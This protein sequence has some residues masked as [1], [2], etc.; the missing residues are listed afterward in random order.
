MAEYYTHTHIFEC[1]SHVAH[2]LKTFTRVCGLTVFLAGQ[3][4][5]ASWT[6]RHNA[7]RHLTVYSIAGKLCEASA[8]PK[9]KAIASAPLGR[10]RAICQC[11]HK[12]VN[13]HKY[14]YVVLWW[15]RVVVC[16]V[17]EHSIMFVR[18]EQKCCDTDL[19]VCWTS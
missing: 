5:E 17:P 16:G 10:S 13:A 18:Q 4:A 1:S 7:S 11:S 8:V 2:F 15:F 19:F 9:A 14:H 6:G 3:P 12:R